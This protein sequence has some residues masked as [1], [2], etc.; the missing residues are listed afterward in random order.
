MRF[1]PGMMGSP[2]LCGSKG[3]L[4]LAGSFFPLSQKLRSAV[5]KGKKMSS[6]R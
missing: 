1:D 2:D 4:S 3:Q 6:T 5:G